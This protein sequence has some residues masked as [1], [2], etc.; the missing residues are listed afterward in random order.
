MPSFNHAEIGNELLS[1]SESARES[2]LR[3]HAR[4]LGLRVSKSRGQKGCGQR[5][6]YF[7]I[8]PDSKCLLSTRDGMDL[9]ELETSLI[10]DQLG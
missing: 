1:N 10:Q 4:S 5:V 6:G 3:R 9:N 7:V 2:R 8:E